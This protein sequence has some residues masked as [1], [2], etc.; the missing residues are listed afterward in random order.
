MNLVNHRTSSLLRSNGR[1]GAGGRVAPEPQPGREIWMTGR[2]RE[3][4]QGGEGNNSTDCFTE[5]FTDVFFFRWWW[6]NFA[7]L[8]IEH[9]FWDYEFPWEVVL[10]SKLRSFVDVFF[11]RLKDCSVGSKFVCHVRFLCSMKGWE[12]GGNTRHT[13]QSSV[14]IV[15]LSDILVLKQHQDRIELVNAACHKLRIVSAGFWKGFWQC[16]RHKSLL[17]S[18]NAC[19][20]YV[21]SIQWWHPWQEE[22]NSPRLTAA[23]SS[24]AGEDWWMV[25]NTTI[26]GLNGCI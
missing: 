17:N 25:L 6:Y 20:A 22:G 2:G 7:D 26:W 15:E 18:W 23:W 1:F 13:K 12:I 21:T 10:N 24:K 5:I 4:S 9:E 3:N 19:E 14:S 16:C 8:V 11:R